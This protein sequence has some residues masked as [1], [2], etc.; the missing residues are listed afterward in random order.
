MSAIINRLAKWRQVY[1][2]MATMGNATAF[3]RYVRDVGEKLLIQRAELSALSGLL[4]QKGVF[5]QLELT[6]QVEVECE[7]LMQLLEGAF[8]G[9]KSSDEGLSIETA[10][11]LLTMQGWTRPYGTGKENGDAKQA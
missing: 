1:A 11:A 7:A 3:E 9:F 5:T 10:A 4:I 8:P 6:A 2:M